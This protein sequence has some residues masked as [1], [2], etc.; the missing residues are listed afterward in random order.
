V[1]KFRMIQGEAIDTQ[2]AHVEEQ[3]DNVDKLILLGMETRDVALVE[4]AMTQRLHAIE[5]RS[6]ILMM[7]AKL[8][9]LDA[10]TKTEV[11]V[12]VSTPVDSAVAELLS[13]MEAG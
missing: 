6:R 11:S 9:G 8:F 13:E 12:T 1:D 7:R 5:A 10:P 4:K 3:L 2:L